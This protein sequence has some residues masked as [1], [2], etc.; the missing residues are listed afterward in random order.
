MA[1]FSGRVACA[2][3]QPQLRKWLQVRRRRVAARLHGAAAWAWLPLSAHRA[4]CIVVANKLTCELARCWRRN[5]HQRRA[6]AIAR[7]SGLRWGGQIGGTRGDCLPGAART[8]CRQAR[9]LSAHWS[10]ARAYTHTHTNL[11][12][13]SSPLHTRFAGGAQTRLPPQPSSSRAYKLALPLLLLFLLF[14]TLSPAVRRPKQRER[15]ANSIDRSNPQSASSFL[16]AVSIAIAGTKSWAKFPSSA[17]AASGPPPP[18]AACVR[19]P[20]RL[21]PLN[22]RADSSG[23]T[24]SKSAK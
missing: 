15:R 7:A 9:A 22:Q 18:R 5:K 3:M 14:V 16:S 2:K 1:S 19:S 23:G 17:L 24:K 21:D 4:G 13:L 8:I 20:S 12:S 10:S 6:M 11:C